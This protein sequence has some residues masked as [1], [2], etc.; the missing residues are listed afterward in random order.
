VLLAVSAFVPDEPVLRVDIVVVSILPPP[1]EPA[2]VVLALVV[3]A[4]MELLPVVMVAESELVVV[5]S[6]PE[7]QAR[8]PNTIPVHINN[9]FILKL[10]II[11]TLPANFSNTLPTDF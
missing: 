8:I 6:V 11:N 7:L 2:L 1:V 3:S 9:L 4:V 5:L 10:F